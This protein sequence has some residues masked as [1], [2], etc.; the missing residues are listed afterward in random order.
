MK[1]GKKYYFILKNYYLELCPETCEEQGYYTQILEP[2][3]PNR[4]R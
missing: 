3:F 2:S 4:A 1:Y